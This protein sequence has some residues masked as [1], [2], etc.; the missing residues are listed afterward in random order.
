M[1]SSNLFA[2]LI[3]TLSSTELS[4]FERHLTTCSGRVKNVYPRNVYQIRE[5]PFDK[6][7][8]FSTEYTS[9]QKLFKNLTIFNFES[10]CVQEESFKDKK[11]TLWIGKHV[12][13]SVSISSNLVEVPFFL[14]NSDPHH[15]VSSFIGT[16]ESQASQSET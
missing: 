15:L 12:P 7:D 4:I 11:T 1:Q 16:L 2:A 13:I 3:V 9:Q 10:I 6:L 8:T 14:Y 5:T